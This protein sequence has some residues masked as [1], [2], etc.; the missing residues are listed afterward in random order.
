MIGRVLRRH[1]FT[2]T[3]LLGLFI[4]AYC[5][6]LLAQGLPAVNIDIGTAEGP[7]DVVGLLQILLLLTLITLAPSLLVMVTPFTRIIVILSL[8]RSALGTQ[9]APPNTV[10]VGIAL[11]LTLFIMAPVNYQINQNA[12]QP[13]L[14]GDIEFGTAIQQ[15]EAPLRKFMLAQTRRRDLALFTEMSRLENVETIDD[16][17]TYVIIPAYMISELKTA[18]QIGFIIFIPFLVIDL[19]VSSVLMSMG[20]LMLPPVLISLPFKL[21][22]FILADGWHLIFASIAKSFNIG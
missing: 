4:A 10:L 15:A 2:L 12:V 6:P 16:I 14:K 13:Y 1:R 5:T 21:L 22:L 3:I 20:M 19:V 7:S 18:F 17:P 9:H 11:F 8:L